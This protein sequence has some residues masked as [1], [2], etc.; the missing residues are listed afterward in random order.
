MSI[1]PFQFQD[2]EIRV[3]EREGE[4][5]FVLADL[6][7]VLD[8]H[9][10]KDVKDRLGDGVAQT[11]PII[12]SLGRTQQATIV[13]EAGMYEVVIRSDKPDA[14]AFRR[15]ITSEVLPSI[16]K[17]GSYGT[18]TLSG[19]ELMAAALQEAASTLAARD[20]RIAAQDRTIAVLEPKAD[21][22]DLWIS[23]NANYSVKDV[24]LALHHAGAETI[25]LDGAKPYS[26]G[27]NNLMRWLRLNG[28]IA[29]HQNTP[30]K[31]AVTSHR[32]T[33][34]LGHYEKHEDRRA[35][36][37]LHPADHHE[38][39]H[40]PGRQIQRDAREGRRVPHRR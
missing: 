33:V 16:R 3:I 40:R 13:S 9:N 14:V 23:S 24:A 2:R 36:R 27:Q 17:T 8:L 32:M 35:D 31:P 29:K 25:V 12:D 22:W 38:G 6:C 34:R 18:P 21:A 4:P 37:H 28:W 30:N 10:T 11:Y 15:W 20:Q 1:V 5:W 26:M 39:R 7:R 19:P